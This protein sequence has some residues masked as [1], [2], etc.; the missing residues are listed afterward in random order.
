[1][2][3]SRRAN[4]ERALGD[5]RLLRIERVIRQVPSRWVQPSGSMI[6]RIIG[7]QLQSG[8]PMIQF[9]L[10]DPTLARTYDPATD[11][12][13]P[14]GLGNAEL[15]GGGRYMGLALARHDFLGFP[16]PLMA[17]DD[18]YVN[19]VI[20]TIAEPQNDPPSE[21]PTTGS[22][23]TVGDDPTGDFEGHEGETAT[24]NGSSYT[25]STE[26]PTVMR[27]YTVKRG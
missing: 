5:K 13:Y 23:I 1:M 21:T 19:T 22:K 3:L 16:S 15:W 11:T 20:Q 27:M 12:V 17:G 10:E 14:V 4:N 8:V 25:F 18:Y 2:D 6:L 9:A 7:G 24:W 26:D